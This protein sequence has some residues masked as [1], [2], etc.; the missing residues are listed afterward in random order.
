MIDSR[1]CH[2]VAVAF[3]H[4]SWH[5]LSP[6]S[7]VPRDVSDSGTAIRFPDPFRGMRAREAAAAKE[8]EENLDVRNLLAVS[9]LGRATAAAPRRDWKVRTQDT[10][11]FDE[12]VMSLVT[13]WWFMTSS[14]MFSS[15]IWNFC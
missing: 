10:E 2:V 1:S 6:F 13:A 5:L 3:L 9:F 7:T 4:G 8:M 11:N 14:S 15:K 12:E